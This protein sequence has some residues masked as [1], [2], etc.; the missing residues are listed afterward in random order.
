MDLGWADG[1]LSGTSRPVAGDPYTLYLTEPEGYYLEDFEAPRAAVRDLQ[2]T[3]GL[4]AITLVSGGSG[5]VAW[6][7]R[8]R[9]K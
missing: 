4:A 8:Y 1:T 2:R 6:Q 9:K 5:T 7:A 3:A